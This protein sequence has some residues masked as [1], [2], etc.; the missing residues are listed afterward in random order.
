MLR[1]LLTVLGLAAFIASSGLSV[2]AQGYGPRYA[3]PPPRYERHGPPPGSGYVWV[4]GYNH[5]NGHAYVWI[6]GGWQRPP[7]YGAVWIPGRYV[8][9]GGYYVWVPGHWS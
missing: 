7:R 3:P 4:G 6:G 1:R 8:N 5:W 9:R 2:S